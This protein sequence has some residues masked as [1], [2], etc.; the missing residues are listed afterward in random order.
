MSKQTYLDLFKRRAKTLARDHGLMLST[1][2]EQLAAKSGFANLHELTT[3]AKRNPNDER[4]TYAAFGTQDLADLICEED[5]Y[6]ELQSEVE[7]VLSGAIAET[8]AYAFG[9]DGLDVTSS[10]Y[11]DES[12]QVWLDLTFQYAGEQDPDKAYHGATFYIMARACMHC[13]QGVWRLSDN[14]G[15]EIL[16][17]KNDRDL[18]YGDEMET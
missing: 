7:D 11:D 3:V 15:L 13:A 12:G 17:C 5:A 8:N 10:T 14:D 16:E 9:I 1:A 4:L 2:Q 18:D 6:R